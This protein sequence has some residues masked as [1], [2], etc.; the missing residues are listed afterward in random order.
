MNK[1]M[2]FILDIISIFALGIITIVDIINL[3]TSFDEL[4]EYYKGGSFISIIILSYVI[5]VL[6][7]DVGKILE[8]DNKE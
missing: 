7:K 4:N 3:L 1:I 6:G 8:L 2:R 5:F